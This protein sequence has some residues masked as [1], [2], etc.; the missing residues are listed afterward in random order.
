MGDDDERGNRAMTI[1]DRP[2]TVTTG[3][4]TDDDGLFGP[5]SVTWRCHTDPT[6]L[7]IGSA[8][9]TTQ[10]L[11]P[12]VMRMIDQASSFRTKPDLRA[13]RTG[14][15][16]M[17][18]TYGDRAAAEHAGATL[19]K[20]HQHATAVDPETGETY[21]A[22]TDDLLLWVHC[23][24][25]WMSLRAWDAYGPALTPRSRT[26]TWSSSASPPASS[27]SRSIESRRRAP[28]RRLHGRDAPAP[29]LH[30]RGRVV[31]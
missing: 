26:S 15:Y 3:L 22:E 7:I 13:Q 23:A 12:R 21:H 10:M 4:H 31:P 17:T 14:E 16:V 5:D 27:P 11:H 2:D 6:M 29:G 25:V 20:I 8:S 28:A 18:I 1:T 9:A 19:R 24:L 30:P